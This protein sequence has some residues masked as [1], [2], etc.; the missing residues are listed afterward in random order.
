MGVRAESNGISELESRLYQ[1]LK[2]PLGGSGPQSND[3]ERLPVPPPAAGPEGV[4]R[5]RRALWDLRQ[6]AA[7]LGTIPAGYPRHIDLIMKVI[8]ALLPWYTRSLV[9]FGQRTVET[10]ETMADAIEPV[11]RAGPH[12][13][14]AAP[15]P[16]GGGAGGQ[17]GC[18]GE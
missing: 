9:Q 6:D 4:E 8:S 13:A 10:L 3:S 14:G 7:R 11:L 2:I 15:G 17:S 16:A 5:I 12:G 1:H 18:R